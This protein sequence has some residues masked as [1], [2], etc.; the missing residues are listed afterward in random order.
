MILT[1]K[2][3]G[4]IV[5]CSFAIN[6]LSGQTIYQDAVFNDIVHET[7]VYF[8]KPDE[9]L[10]LDIFYASEDTTSNKPVL[11]YVHGGGF[12]GGHRDSERNIEFCTAM[13]KKGY[14]AVTMSYTLIMKGK[15]F[16]CEQPAS[17][18][19]STFLS[20]GRDISRAVDFLIHHRLKWNIDT[21][22]IVIAGSSAGA[23]AVL[24]AAFWQQTRQD[25]TGS[26]LSTDFRYAG[27]ISMA[28]AITD[29]NLITEKTAIPV[30]CFHGTC[31]NLVPYA[32]AAHHYC[33]MEKP[34]YLVLHGAKSIADRLQFLGKPFYLFTA[35]K[36]RHEWASKPMISNREEITDFLYNDVMLNQT[37]QIHLIYETGKEKCPGNYPTF[38]FCQE[39]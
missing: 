35:C 36:G 21:N 34:G 12:S 33:P 9:Q 39:N 17:N 3:I 6:A 19:I 14:I 15:S 7:R 32:T 29:L 10:G 5:V 16:G 8:S 4:F 18:K 1:M 11:L 27:V 31:D 30:Q 13:A 24:H 37:R 23:E 28:G 26:I 38:R 20:S 22:K 25:S 2:S